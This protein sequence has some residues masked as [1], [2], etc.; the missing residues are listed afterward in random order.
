MS[1][2]FSKM[3]FIF[4]VKL[5]VDS[6]GGSRKSFKN[7]IPPEKKIYKTENANCIYFFFF[8]HLSDVK[9]LQ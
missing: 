1:A 6:T 4:T 7:L 5:N 8:N 9:R 2:V 3:P